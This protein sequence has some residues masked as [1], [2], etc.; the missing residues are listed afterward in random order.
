MRSIEL[1]V[2][3]KYGKEYNNFANYVKKILYPAL[4]GL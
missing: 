3:N 4:D 2:D 1:L